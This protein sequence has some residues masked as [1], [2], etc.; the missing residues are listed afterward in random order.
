MVHCHTDPSVK[1]LREL[2]AAGVFVGLTGIVA[3]KREGRFNE[4]IVR[5]IPLSRLMVET[6]AP[7]LMPRN[8]PR[9][10]WGERNEACLLP[11]V[12][13]KIARIRGHCTEQ[14]VAESTTK[15]AKE[16]FGL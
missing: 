2:L 16:F 4:E 9:E 11:F 15:L 14:E 1:N 8:V 13:K 6:D 10:F 3:D 5:E 7:F 12:V